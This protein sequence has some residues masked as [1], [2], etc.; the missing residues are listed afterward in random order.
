MYALK[1]EWVMSME[2]YTFITV[3]YDDIVPEIVFSLTMQ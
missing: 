1:E 3:A 2:V